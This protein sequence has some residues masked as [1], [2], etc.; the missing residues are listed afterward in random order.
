M[1]LLPLQIIQ[2]LIYSLH[3]QGFKRLY[4]YIYY[5]LNHALN[6]VFNL[7]IQRYLMSCH[8]TQ[9]RSIVSVCHL[10]FLNTKIP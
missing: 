3:L 2:Q 4:Y 10:I 9:I 7:F 1:A 8:K 5:K 6:R